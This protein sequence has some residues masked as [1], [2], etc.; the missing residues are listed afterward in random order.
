VAETA[1]LIGAEV[2]PVA[3]VY[4]WYVTVP[5][6]EEAAAVSVAAVPLKMACDCGCSENDG[7]VQT[8]TTMAGLLLTQTPALVTSAQ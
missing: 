5:V 2:S 3:P 6:G 7:G 4:H 1:P 8:L